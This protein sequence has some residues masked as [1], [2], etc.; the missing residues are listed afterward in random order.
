MAA[1]SQR[2]LALVRHLASSQDCESSGSSQ[3]AFHR[4]GVCAHSRRAHA[5]GP[6]VKHPLA[7]LKVLVLPMPGLKRLILQRTPVR[8][9]E[10]PGLWPVRTIDRIQMHGGDQVILAPG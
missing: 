3:L 8:E 5:L 1:E 2:W 9:T 6:M 10:L 4:C 7:R